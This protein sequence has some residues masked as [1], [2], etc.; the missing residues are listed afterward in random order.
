MKGLFAKLAIGVAALA[1][2]TAA[3]AGETLDRVMGKKAMVVATNSG[4]P[5]QSFLDDRTATNWSASTSTFPRRSPSAS[6]SK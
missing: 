3:Q 4:W 1:F 2:V 6:A 5:P